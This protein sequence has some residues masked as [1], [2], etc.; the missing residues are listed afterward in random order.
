M[1]L[2]NLLT[3]PWQTTSDPMLSLLRTTRL[4]P[5]RVFSITRGSRVYHRRGITRGERDPHTSLTSAHVLVSSHD[6]FYQRSS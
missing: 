4:T 5:R 3:F 1:K 2:A 6:I